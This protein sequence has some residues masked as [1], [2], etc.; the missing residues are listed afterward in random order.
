MGQ[1]LPLSEI[2]LYNA[3]IAKWAEDSAHAFV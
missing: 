2:F 3:F 1:I